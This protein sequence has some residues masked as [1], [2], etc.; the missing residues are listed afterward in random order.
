MGR[1]EM[2]PNQRGKARL[3]FCTGPINDFFD[4]QKASG[5]TIAETV[6]FAI[7]TAYPEAFEGHFT[8]LVID[9]D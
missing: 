4:Q 1:P 6:D 3:I 7:R 9:E 5:H 8:K 2:K